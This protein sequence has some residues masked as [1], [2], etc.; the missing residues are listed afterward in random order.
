MIISLGIFCSCSCEQE[1]HVHEWTEINKT[2]A[3][4]TEDGKITY[5]CNGCEE[6]EVIVIEQATGHTEVI[7]EA[8]EATCTS[9]GLTEGKHCSK[10]NEVLV[11][12]KVVSVLD[13]EESKE[14]VENNIS[15]TCTEDGFYDLVVYC[16]K[17]TEELSRQKITVK[18]L[19]HDIITHQCK[20][21]T[22]TEDG[23][24]SYEE[25]TRCEYTTYEE[26][27]SI[28]HTYSTELSKDETGHWYECHCKDRKD[29]SAHYSSGGATEYEA[30]VCT[31]CSYVIT[32]E[33][34]HE[35]AYNLQVENDETLKVAA[36]CITNAIYWYS[37]RCTKISTELTYEKEDS[38][39]GHT[40]LDVVK[41]NEV[42]ST[43]KV[44]GSY[45]S[46]VYCS[47]C[48]VEI[49]RE[50]KTSPLANHTEEVVLGKTATCTETGLTEGSHCSVCNE[51]L[52]AQEVLPTLGH[53]YQ[54]VIDKEATLSATGIKHEECSRCKDIKNENTIINVLVCE[55]NLQKIEAVA[56]TCTKEGNSE[57]Y[58]CV[59]CLKYYIDSAGNLLIE[60]YSWII[61]AKGH[62]KIKLEAIKPTC[63]TTGLTEGEKCSVCNEV[64]VKQEEIEALD[65]SYEIIYD[66]QEDYNSVTATATCKNDSN[67]IIIETV[68]SSSI[69][70]QKQNCEEY[71]MTKYT[72]TFENELFNT[73]IKENVKTKEPLG[74]TQVIDASVDATCESSGL[75]EGLHCSK[76]NKVL[77]DQKVIPALG[78][79]YTSNVTYPTATTNGIAI[80]TCS[81]GD[82]YNETIIPTDFTVT[83]ANRNLVGYTG[84][85]E[86]NL[87][88][89]AIFEENGTWY[90]VVSIGAYA[91]ES[92][93]NLM[94][95]TIPDSVTIIG[96]YAFHCCKN[97]TD[98]LIPESV[99]YIGSRAFKE[100]NSI[101]SV[102]I[103][104]GVALDY[105]AFGWCEKLNNV[106][107]GN[108]VSFCGSYVFDYCINLESVVI[109]EGVTCIGERAFYE[110]TSLTR[111]VIPA[112]VTSFEIS[113]FS[114]CSSLVSITFGGTIAQWKVIEKGTLWDYNTGSYTIYCT[115]GEITKD[116]TI[117]FNF[118]V[119][120]A[121]RDMIGYTGKTDEN[122]VIPSMF[123]I[124]GV[125]YE[126][127]SIGDEAFMGC[128]KLATV[129]IPDSVISIG[130]Y[131]FHRCNRLTS[132]TIGNGVICIGRDAFSVCTGLTSVTIPD[133]VTNLDEDGVFVNCSSLTCFI[134]G[135]NNPN[136]KSIDGN[137]YSKDG[138]TL[139]QYAIGKNATE[140]IIS[141]DVTTIGNSAFNYCTL[142]NITLPDNVIIIGIQA[143]SNSKSLIS[144]TI[145]RGV[146][147]IGWGA[148]SYCNSLTI[149][150]E[151]SSKPSGW[152]SDWNYS[153][154]PVY[155]AGEWKYDSNGNPVP[156]S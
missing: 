28:G 32:H 27:K 17:C 110:C 99:T 91:F 147:K 82:S 65:H 89:P 25:C 144:V 112:S 1:D 154:R 13:H 146:T 124:N 83:N 67:H 8:I 36:T 2:I 84:I 115:D 139:I 108:N 113:A 142:T 35:H 100:C 31:I 127:T 44:A 140:F 16:S 102:I 42:A 74:H 64:F 80:Y 92:C 66:W 79:T 151:A 136:Y 117:I 134:V 68:K 109:G 50:E 133:S 145:G 132:V 155:W 47:V 141:S 130:D 126:V 152:D 60:E 45:D 70:S 78:H 156:L 101:T 21:P 37:C 9:T 76:C 97:L 137:I 120:A 105:L 122:L 123:E 88:I 118:T 131:A 96:D 103:P 34:G 148:F 129:I 149:Y 81:C 5:K 90:R 12:Q 41:E 94:S 33:L 56:A 6:T 11:E 24:R 20:E 30:E 95:V 111:I 51:V 121:N 77:V 85:E 143:F 135:E 125:W 55:H 39:L 73:Q 104:D 87:V 93:T 40:N 57:Y 106:I 61:A 29:F 138:K 128:S 62:N 54:W 69:V 14:I 63:I 46:V 26:I 153:N 22:C 59:D 3:T 43:C 119:T 86:E 38:A 98:I 52:V 18:A 10:C 7:D 114:L 4:C 15:P 72:A 116:G 48:E 53:I 23:Y 150:C 58:H 49:S 19:G 75:T 71:E 107:I